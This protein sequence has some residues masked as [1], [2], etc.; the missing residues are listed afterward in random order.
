[1]A[2]KITNI[3]RVI[4]GESLSAI[5]DCFG[6]SC[7]A[8]CT[9]IV[10]ALYKPGVCDGKGSCVSLESNPCSVHGCDKKLCGDE[11]LS[12]DIKG[13][14]DANGECKFSRR[15]IKCGKLIDLVLLL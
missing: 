2:R 5:V 12:G 7:G 9:T 8:P 10:Q 4:I 6:Q 15:Y 14:C 1:M 3:I 11:C 13:W